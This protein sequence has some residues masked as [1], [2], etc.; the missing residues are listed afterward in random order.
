[1][2][3][4]EKR[5]EQWR[6]VLLWYQAI[7]SLYQ[8]ILTFS[9]KISSYCP[10]HPHISLKLEWLEYMQPATVIIKVLTQL[11]ES[12][13]YQWP[14]RLHISKDSILTWFVVIS[15]TL[16]VPPGLGASERGGQ[17]PLAEGV[18]TRQEFRL[19]VVE[20]QLTD[21]T[22]VHEPEGA[23]LF[24]PLLLS[25]QTF[26]LIFH[27]DDNIIAGNIFST[28]IHFFFFLLLLLLRLMSRC[29][30]KQAKPVDFL[31]T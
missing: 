2:T 30:W 31:L 18:K 12:W 21:G 20:T 3:V 10:H 29:V 23:L 5:N 7:L 4:H 24:Q 8:S 6:P 1:M 25:W 15:W 16:W 26:R 22:S 19:S 9:K 27:D 13:L 28:F 14:K 17:T 11:H